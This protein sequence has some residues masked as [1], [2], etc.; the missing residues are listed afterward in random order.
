MCLV[1]VLQA[2]F[3]Y[4]AVAVY[5]N[6]VVNDAM[7]H[8]YVPYPCHSNDIKLSATVGVLYSARSSSGGSR[9]SSL[10]FF[11]SQVLYGPLGRKEL[12]DDQ[13]H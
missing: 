3:F 9:N 10:Y 2:A 5:V 1:V 8:N 13:V 7:L 11:E 6:T 4:E 12:C